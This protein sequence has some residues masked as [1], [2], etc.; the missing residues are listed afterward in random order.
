MF[1]HEPMLESLDLHSITTH[2]RLGRFQAACSR[3]WTLDINF[4]WQR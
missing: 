1:W 3:T 4:D 2:Q